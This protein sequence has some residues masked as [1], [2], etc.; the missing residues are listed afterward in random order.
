[1]AAVSQPMSADPSQ[2]RQEVIE[3]LDTLRRN[4]ASCDVTVAVKGEKFKAHKAVLAA[5]SPFFRS[6]LESNM[7]E[8]NEQLIRIELEE[9]TASVMEDVLKY[10]YTGN[11]SVTEE[12]GHNLIATADYLLLPGLKTAACDFVKENVTTENCVFNYYFAVKYQCAELKEKSREL[13]NANFSVVIETEDFLN[14]D[15]DQVMEWV[16]SDDVNVSF[17][18]QI[19]NGIVKWVSH[20]KGER[21]K[22]FAKLLRQVRLFS[23]SQDFLLN[24]VVKQE[25]VK[26]D[27]ECLN[28]VLD[29][30]KGIFIH[31]DS[32]CVTQTPR[33]CLETHSDVIFVC[34]GIMSFCYV[35]NQNK[36][37]QLDDMVLEHQDHAVVQFRD[38]VYVFSPRN[39]K[40]SQRHTVEYYMSSNNSWGTIATKLR[41]NVRFSSV[42]VRNNA[43][44][45][46]VVAEAK[47]EDR[48]YE[49]DPEWNQWDVLGMSVL[50][51]WGTC[52]VNDGHH[53]YIIGGSHRG[54]PEICGTSTVERCNSVGFLEEITAMNEARHDAFGAAMNGK[55]YVAGGF[56]KK[57]HICRVVDTCEVYNPSTNEWQLMPSL[58]VPRQSASMVCFKGALYVVGGLRDDRQ[59]ELSVEMFDSETNE[60]IE[61]STIP[62]ICEHV[63]G[64]GKKP[65]YKACFA[66]IHKH[67]LWKTPS[68]RLELDLMQSRVRAIFETKK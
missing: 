60:W 38:K 45:V 25:L 14:L 19:F 23:L 53:F 12:S 11:V 4:E 61:K 2:H 56:Q 22:D 33:K 54:D 6:L 40:C 34:G 43:M 31:S 28:F 35:P 67:A 39:G 49:Y 10:V 5:T 9:A 63:G 18:K 64:T 24:D 26:A 29:A 8:S 20:S 52:G 21:E 65:N 1:M 51:R 59:R 16:S 13:I 15:V 66:R 68:Q 17:E 27:S 47:R 36:W 42:S 58:N 55:I 32:E 44:Y 37:Y 48:T 62:V 57:G 30:L 46:L 50:R 41:F 3:R 7:R